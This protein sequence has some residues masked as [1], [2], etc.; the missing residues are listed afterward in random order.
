MYGF[1]S[2][3]SLL[4]VKILFCFEVEIGI[5]NDGEQT[6]RKVFRSKMKAVK[7]NRL[8]LHNKT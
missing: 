7:Q 3:V 4:F 8:K 1:N 5:E 2:K 6:V